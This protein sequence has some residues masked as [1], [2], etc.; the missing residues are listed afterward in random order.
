MDLALIL[1][2]LFVFVLTVTSPGPANIRIW[3]QAMAYGHKPATALALGVGVVSLLWSL[4]AL[5]GLAKVIEFDHDFLLHIEVVGGVYLLWLAFKS[6]RSAKHLKP[7]TEVQ[8]LANPASY[9]SQFMSGAL[10]HA[11]N[12]KAVFLWG[13]VLTMATSAKG[14]DNHTIAILMICNTIAFVVFLSYAYVFSR[15]AAMA[16]YTKHRRF[17]EIVTA[18]VFLS[19]GTT[20]IADAIL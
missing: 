14:H 8:D 1:P 9:A 18:I 2:I 16:F 7:L 19:S 11:T 20:L 6:A 10:I 4:L 5:I 3:Q 13:L 15:P 17:I 12:P